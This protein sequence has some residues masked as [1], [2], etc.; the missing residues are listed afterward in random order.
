MI[1]RD[2]LSFDVC[3]IASVIESC[4]SSIQAK[5]TRMENNSVSIVM[6]ELQG[7]EAL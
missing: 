3:S 4:N 6:V 1:E 5:E 7:M 2:S